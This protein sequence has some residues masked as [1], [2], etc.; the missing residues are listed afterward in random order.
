[1]AW[2]VAEVYVLSMVAKAALSPARAKGKKYAGELEEKFN[3]LVES[4]N[5]KIETVK[6]EASRIA[7]MAKLKA[8][9]IDDEVTS[10]TK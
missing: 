7:K 6:D 8:E 1:M 4:I 10:F 9:Q 2:S 5:E 3:G